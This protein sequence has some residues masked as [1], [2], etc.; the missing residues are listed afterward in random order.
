MMPVEIGEAQ[1]CTVS[2]GD[3]DGSIQG[4]LLKRKSRP[5]QDADIR[6]DTPKVRCRRCLRV[7]RAVL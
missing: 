5:N 6:D 4:G 1:R 3:K 7:S 2:R